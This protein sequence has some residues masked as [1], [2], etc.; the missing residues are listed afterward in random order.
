MTPCTPK[1]SILMPAYNASKTI[2]RAIKSTLFQ[3]FQEWELIIVNDGSTDE[4][5]KI[6]DSFNEPRIKL[7]NFPVNKGRGEARIASLANANGEYITMLDADD[8]MYP[9]R[10]SVQFDSL[11]KNSSIAIHCIG[12][13]VVD[14]QDRLIGVRGRD[15]ICFVTKT[16]DF[17]GSHAAC[18]IR[19]SVISNKSYKSWLR[20]GQD[21]DFLFRV[22]CGHQIQLSSEIGY[23][24]TEIESFRL[25]K[26]IKMYWYSAL[27][28]FSNSKYRGY[29]SS[30]MK[31]G[32]QL[33]KIPITIVIFFAFGK[34]R[35]LA[36]RNNPP[37][38]AQINLHDDIKKSLCIE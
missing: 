8:W 15:D 20:Y 33:L 19:R 35:L 21:Q 28:N 29:F 1:I 36:N 22:A 32:R 2:E 25:V 11:T 31:G 30:L 38:K 13:G 34:D 4:T 5:A 17:P 6:V 27:S 3:T 16:G 9:N 23:I 12:L 14:D 7:I 24:Y 37:N 18:M 10:L 26:L